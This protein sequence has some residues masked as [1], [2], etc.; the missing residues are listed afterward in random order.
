MLWSSVALV[1]ITSP[2]ESSYVA[3]MFTSDN[4]LLPYLKKRWF[5]PTITSRKKGKYSGL[6]KRPQCRSGFSDPTVA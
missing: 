6:V 4:I 3:G 5:E 2:V 1:A